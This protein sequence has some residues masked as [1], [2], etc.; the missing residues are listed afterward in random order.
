MHCACCADVLEEL[1]LLDAKRAG[2]LCVH[3]HSFFIWKE[4]FGRRFCVPQR[5]PAL[6]RGATDVEVLRYWLTNPVAREQLVDLLAL[7]CERLIELVEGR[8]DGGTE[9]RRLTVACGVEPPSRPPA[10]GC[11]LAIR[12]RRD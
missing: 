8:G 1:P 10:K 9:A 7:V 3:G 4:P 5:V 11:E 2:Y 12:R 6:A